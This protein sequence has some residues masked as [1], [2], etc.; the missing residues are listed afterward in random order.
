MVG[1]K[2]QAS[3]IIIFCDAQKFLREAIASVFAQTY[4]NWELI[5]VDDGS[6]DGSSTLAKS[7]A[8]EMPRRVRYLDHPGHKNGGMSASRN[9]GIAK[10]SGAYIA[11]FS[12]FFS[13][14]LILLTSQ[15]DLVPSGYR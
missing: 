1:R 3:V 13:G 15:N 5:L 8:E 14:F 10:S 4:E 12:V 7:C 11:F 2:P 9:L 6:A